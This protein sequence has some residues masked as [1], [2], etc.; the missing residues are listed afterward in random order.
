MKD[1]KILTKENTAQIIVDGNEINDVLEYTL[2]EN[3]EG[4]FLTLKIFISGSIEVQ[5]GLKQ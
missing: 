4:A 3:A 5:M 1:L 2:S